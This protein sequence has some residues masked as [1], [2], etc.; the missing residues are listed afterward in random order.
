VRRR[1]DGSLVDVSLTVSPV[2]NA[3][4]KVTG[5]SKIARDISARKKAEHERLLALQ[6]EDRRR[7]A[8]RIKTVEV[9]LEG[10]RTG[11]YVPLRKDDA[12]LGMISCTRTETRPFSDK[13][14]ALVENFV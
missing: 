1:K 14:I 12:L 4:G 5:V 11:L 10:V 9:E 7:I 3:A 6:D 8:K 13:E 2:R